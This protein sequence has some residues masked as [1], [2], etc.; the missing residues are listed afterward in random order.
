MVRGAFN[1]NINYG[2]RLMYV[3]QKNGYGPI[4]QFALLQLT[5]FLARLV[6]D[7]N[8]AWLEFTLL[9]NKIGFLNKP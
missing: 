1:D 4:F 5:G 6:S 9:D 2:W 3:T 7:K 8:I